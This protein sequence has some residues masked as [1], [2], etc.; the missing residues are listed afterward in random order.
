MIAERS[1][2]K[3]FDEVVEILSR[4]SFHNACDGSDEIHLARAA[5][6][7]AAAICFEDRW[8]VWQMEAARTE[9]SQLIA[10]DDLVQTVLKLAWRKL[11]EVAP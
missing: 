5:M 2:P 4:V 10:R 1:K 3:R 7:E 8:Y 9:R 11:G 6:E